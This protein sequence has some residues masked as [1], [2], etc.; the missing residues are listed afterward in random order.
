MDLAMLILR[1]VLGLT[2]AAHGAQ[3][4]FGWFKGP[5]MAGTVGMCQG[6][7]LRQPEV[8]ARLLV[9]AELGGGLLLAFGLLTPFG[10]AGVIGSMA[11]AIATVHWSKGFFSS[12]GGYE[13]NLLIATSALAVA[14]AGP[15]RISIDSA[16]GLS[17]NGALWGLAA[18]AIGAGAAM[19][20]LAQR[21]Q[22]VPASV[23]RDEE[24]EEAARAA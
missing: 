22:P 9:L 13:F 4:L 19:A 3:K 1:V 12:N 10:A 23:E 8:H 14:I 11:A 21:H 5:G 7:G 20:V 2:M 24:R 16:L 18:L 6:M 17:L 15:G